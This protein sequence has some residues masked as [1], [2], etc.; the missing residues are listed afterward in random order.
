MQIHL[1]GKITQTSKI[2]R[3]DAPQQH[4]ADPADLFAIMSFPSERHYAK[5]LT[6]DD[7][8]ALEDQGV[9]ESFILTMQLSLPPKEQKIDKYAREFGNA[10]ETYGEDWFG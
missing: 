5:Y 3:Y 7:H 10:Y 9:K 4:D 1:S 2:E 6:S 8:K